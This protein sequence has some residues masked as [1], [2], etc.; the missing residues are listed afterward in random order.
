MNRNYRIFIT[1][2]A[3][4]DLAKL[5]SKVARRVIIKLRRYEAD[6]DPLRHA[7][8][9]KGLDNTYRFRIGDY[10]AIFE[11]QPDGTIT[12]LV[13]LRIRHRKDVYR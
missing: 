12:L 3:E 9:L 1:H 8:Q 13:I 6:D 5:E 7:K 2:S 4:R 11:L 10:R